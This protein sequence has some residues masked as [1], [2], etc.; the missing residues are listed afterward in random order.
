MTDLKSIL[1]NMVMVGVLMI[2]IISFIIII[3]F[4]GGVDIEER[5]TNNSIINESFG[6]LEVTLDKQKEAQTALNSS[7]KDPPQEYT[8]DLDIS[9]TISTTLT[10]GDL[11]IGVWNIYIKLPQVVFGV[12]P[13][14]ASAITTILIIFIIIAIWAVKKGAIS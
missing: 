11:I 2:S 13:I 9:S 1:A 10:A 4:D 8:G 3:Q 5:I 14:V 7:E 6:K 12:N